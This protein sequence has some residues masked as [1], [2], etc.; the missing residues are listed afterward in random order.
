MSFVI[1]P[2]EGELLKDIP[3][4]Y[5]KPF[6]TNAD[7]RCTSQAYEWY[8]KM[9]IIF[10]LLHMHCYAED[11]CDGLSTNYMFGYKWNAG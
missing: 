7:S 3:R 5:N 8:D 2:T 11:A 6:Q 4:H 1:K 10:P 9:K